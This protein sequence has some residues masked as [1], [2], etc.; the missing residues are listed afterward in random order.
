MNVNSYR[1][2]KDGRNLS[3]LVFVPR[4][5]NFHGSY[6]SVN[7]PVCQFSVQCCVSA[8][9][10]CIQTLQRLSYGFLLFK[11]SQILEFHQHSPKAQTYSSS[12]FTSFFS[13]TVTDVCY[14]L[15]RQNSQTA[16]HSEVFLYCLIASNSA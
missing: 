6:R 5:L 8:L 15:L 16:H 1:P 4:V 2:S 12:S 11:L 9:M 10:T 7:G 3:F 13:I 14:F